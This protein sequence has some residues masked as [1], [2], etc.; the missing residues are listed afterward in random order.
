MEVAIAGELKF[1]IISAV[2]VVA[3]LCWA[4]VA[5][6][7]RVA[8]E[9]T[10]RELFAYVAEGSITPEQAKNLLEVESA[11]QIQKAVTDAVSWGVISAKDAES[12]I[13]GN[14]EEART[15]KADPSPA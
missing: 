15:A 5:S 7:K 4:F 11:E 13:R 3:L 8:K 2:G 6:I 14:A 9:R 1:V 12:L 10:R